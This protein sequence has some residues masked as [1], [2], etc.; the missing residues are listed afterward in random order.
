MQET[1]DLGDYMGCFIIASKV[2][3]ETFSKVSNKVTSQLPKWKAYSHIQSFLIPKSILDN[4][5][6]SYGNF[7]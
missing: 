1:N 2:T 5:D 3:K 6:K 7:F 4:L